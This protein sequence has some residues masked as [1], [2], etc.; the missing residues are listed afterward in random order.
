MTD[1]A[2][3]TAASD[4]L[5]GMVVYRTARAQLLARH[6]DVER[7]DHLSREAVALADR[8]DFLLDRGDAL[9]ARGVVLAAS[10]RA[11]DAAA[12]FHQAEDVYARKGSTVCVGRARAALVGLPA[13]PV[14]QR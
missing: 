11:E 13:A 9:M 3:E 5:S 10:G 7:A 6:G 1:V 4:D 8:T 12:A 2:E 14:A